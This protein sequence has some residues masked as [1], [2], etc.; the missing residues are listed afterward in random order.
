MQPKTLWGAYQVAAEGRDLPYYK[1][2]LA[3]H[4]EQS[5]AAAEAQAEDERKRQEAEAKKAEEDVE[6][7]D[8]DGEAK[9]KKEKKRKASK[10]EQV[11]E[12]GK[13]G[14]VLVS[15]HFRTNM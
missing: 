3:E 7:V 13:V 10:E 9:P 2:M 6:M 5:I 4:E 12:D 15:F 1:Q 11:G 8:A 14:S